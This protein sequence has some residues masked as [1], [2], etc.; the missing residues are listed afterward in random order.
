MISNKAF[1]M[2][3]SGAAKLSKG[4]LARE[5]IAIAIENQDEE[6]KHSCFY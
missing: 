2:I 5:R 3:L 6:D 4:E 1:T